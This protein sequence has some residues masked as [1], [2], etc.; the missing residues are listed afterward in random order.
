MKVTWVEKEDLF[1]TVMAKLESVDVV[2]DI[3]CGIMPQPYV[4]PSVHICCEPFDQYVEHLQN[5]IKY[6][7]DRTYVVLKATWEEAIRFFPCK[8]VDTVFLVDVI[9]HLEKAESIRL[10][11]ATEGI[12]RSQ[13][14]VFTPLG[15]LP[16]CH[17][18]GKD[19]WGLNGARWQEHKS[20]WYPEDFDDSWE[21][22]A[23]MVFHATDN[24]G[25]AFHT[26]FGAMWAVKS[27]DEVGED[28]KIRRRK[29]NIRRLRNLAVDIRNSI[30]RDLILSLAKGGSRFARSKPFHFMM[31]LFRRADELKK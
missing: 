22:F 4:R 7:L 29:E 27:F 15:F 2:L 28:R 21:I 6:D 20:G 12:A 9:E 10:L 23:S 24:M 1:P 11:K 18:D 26:P 25:K 3:G 31:K 19:A 16:Q 13:V 8:S 17:T 5:K 30:A 14:A